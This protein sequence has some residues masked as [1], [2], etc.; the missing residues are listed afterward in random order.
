MEEALRIGV[1]LEA[2]LTAVEMWR[3]GGPPKRESEESPASGNTTRPRPAPV[4]PRE[5]TEAEMVAQ[6]NAALAALSKQMGGM[7]IG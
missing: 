4:T 3:A 7:K 2:A 6:N 5:K 1:P